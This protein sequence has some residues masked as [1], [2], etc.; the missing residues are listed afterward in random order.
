MLKKKKSLQ[1]CPTFLEGTLSGDGGR[2]AS[3]TCG[4]DPSKGRE[5]C[6]I[7][8]HSSRVSMNVS[9]VGPRRDVASVIFCKEKNIIIIYMN[10]YILHQRNMSVK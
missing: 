4:C 3:V 9:Q 7:F 1:S 6:I 5:L 10:I 8:I 2:A